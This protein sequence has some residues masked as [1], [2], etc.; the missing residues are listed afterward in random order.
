M[1]AG[2]GVARTGTT[3]RGGS[4]DPRIIAVSL[5]SLLLMR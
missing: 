1:P 5:P 4:P 2:A 3:L